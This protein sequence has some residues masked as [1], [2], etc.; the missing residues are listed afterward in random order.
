MHVL[1]ARKMKLDKKS[2]VG[3][4]LGYASMTKGYIIYNLKEKRVIISRNVVVD[5]KS[6]WNWDSNKVE[7]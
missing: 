5:E 2:E 7:Q 3:I 1:A 6:F 4:F